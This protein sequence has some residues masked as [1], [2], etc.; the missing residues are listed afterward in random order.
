MSK[1]KNRKTLEYIPDKEEAKDLTGL[2]LCN[3]HYRVLIGKDKCVDCKQEE[4]E[5]KDTQPKCQFCGK[6]ATKPRYK[7]DE[8]YPMAYDLCDSCAEEHKK[9]WD[10]LKPT[11]QKPIWADEYQKRFGDYERNGAFMYF[12][13][14]QFIKEVEKAAYEQGSSQGYEQG[15][16][17]ASASYLRLAKKYYKEMP[18]FKEVDYLTKKKV[19]LAFHQG[20]IE[21]L[22]QDIETCDIYDFA[23][24]IKKALQDKLKS[25]ESKH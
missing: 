10:S 16:K 18:I 4:L 8:E 3:I 17:E 13:V 19:D 25:L 22:N 12:S 11:D 14:K 9:A 20:Q 5:P 15:K 6:P 2:L 21:Q 24:E 7:P 23:G 1:V